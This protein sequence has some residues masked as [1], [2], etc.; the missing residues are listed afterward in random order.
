MEFMLFCIVEESWIVVWH[1][2]I[3]HDKKYIF[4]YLE[5]G[6]PVMYSRVLNSVTLQ[7]A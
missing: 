7:A 3:G 4:R 5:K 2:C 1:L 6:Y